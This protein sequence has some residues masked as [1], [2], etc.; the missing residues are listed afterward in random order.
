M[1]GIYYKERLGEGINLYL[2]REPKFKTVSV[3]LLVHRS[4][5]VNTTGNALLPR[6]LK[7]GNEDLRDMG[8]I[9]RFLGKCYGA[10][11]NVDVLK[12]GDVQLIYMGS[13]VISDKYTIKGEGVVADILHFLTGLIERPLIEGTGFKE[14]YFNQEKH[15]LGELINSRINDKIQYSID[16]CYEEM[17]KGQPFGRYRYGGT[18]ELKSLTPEGLA[19]HY[20]DIITEAPID[21]FVVGDVDIADLKPFLDNPPTLKR[22][23]IKYP[24]QDVLSIEQDKPR[25]VIEPMDVSQGKITIGYTTGVDYADVRYVPMLVYNSILGGGAH[26]KLFN[27][28][29]E[30]ASLAYYSFSRLESFKGLM[31][32]GAGIEIDNYDKTLGIINE[33][34]DEMQ[35]GN[36]SDSELTAAKKAL[37]NGIHSMQDN[38]LQI[39][40]FLINKIVSGH[41]MTPEVLVERIEQ[42]T[43]EDVTGIADEI[44]H[45]VTYFLTS[46][47]RAVKEEIKR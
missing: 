46:N 47:K 4:L 16:R 39:V 12:K 10:S 41:D 6:V 26:S 5:D 17:A 23:D 7:R 34:L 31:V 36:I 37:I 14:E 22:L 38:Q 42:V 1:E 9:E 32:I 15:N 45:V 24:R 40:D 25:E 18:E 28:V 30:K 43:K 29:R 35:G 27:N 11:L 21:I 33:Q 20:E 44:E 13:D 2:I 3:N 8:A 19:R